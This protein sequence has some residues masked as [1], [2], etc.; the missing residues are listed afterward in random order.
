[1]DRPEIAGEETGAADLS[2]KHSP[3][4]SAGCRE[5]ARGSMAEAESS[6]VPNLRLRLENSAAVWTARADMLE[7]LARQR[8]HRLAAGNAADPGASPLGQ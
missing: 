5:L 2:G 4:S 7:R 1:M 3:N 8:N 6:I